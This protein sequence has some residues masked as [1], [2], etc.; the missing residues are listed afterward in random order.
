MRSFLLNNLKKQLGSCLIFNLSR[1]I[2]EVQPLID[3]F[4][5]YFKV[6]MMKIIMGSKKGCVGQISKLSVSRLIFEI[7]N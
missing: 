7:L 5:G 3:E 4:N 6:G 1:L 2:I